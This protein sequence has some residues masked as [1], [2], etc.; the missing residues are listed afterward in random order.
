MIDRIAILA[1]LP[2]A[3]ASGVGG[4]TLSAHQFDGGAAHSVDES[5]HLAVQT[6][7]FE[8]GQAIVGTDDP[9]THLPKIVRRAK[10]G[11]FHTNV[12]ADGRAVRMVI[13]TGAT[14][15]IMSTGLA[16]RHFP[17]RLMEARGKVN[18]VGG[19]VDYR[20]MQIDQLT[21]GSRNLR[22][23]TIAVVDGRDEF[24]LLGQDVLSKIG[25]IGIN[26]EELTL[27]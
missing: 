27:P 19:L 2:F 16:K 5:A 13:D 17:G 24:A 22:N 18:T 6:D 9:R 25:P 26:G 20:V 7:F 3:L 8:T 21:V 11:L 23:M 12:V 14:N 4:W 1:A 10:D 15:T